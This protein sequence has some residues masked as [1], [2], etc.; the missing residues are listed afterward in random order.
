MSRESI[1][2]RVAAATE[3]PWTR[4]TVGHGG[5]IDQLAAV[6]HALEATNRKAFPQERYLM[7]DL[8]W[9][10]TDTQPV[11]LVGNGPKQT[12]NGDLLAHA[13][14]DVPALLAIADAAAAV[15]AMYP[16]GAAFVAL[17]AAL[18]ALEALP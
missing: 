14:Q 11:A 1:R 4:V 17:R 3:G 6:G 12:E 9:V 8:T 16:G 2:A 5:L 18:D 13:R 7:T 15:E 10:E